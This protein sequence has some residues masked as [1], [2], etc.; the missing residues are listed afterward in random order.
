MSIL[1]TPS[2]R[3]FQ[4]IMLIFWPKPVSTCR[5][6]RVGC[7][8]ARKRS[9]PKPEEACSRGHGPEPRWIILP[10]G[11]SF[12]IEESSSMSQQLCPIGCPLIS[13]SY[14]DRGWRISLSTFANEDS[15][16]LME[17]MKVLSLP[18]WPRSQYWGVLP[19][20][21]WDQSS[22]LERLSQKIYW[23][24]E[25]SSTWGTTSEPVQRG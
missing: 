7:L 23:E 16:N 10:S 9:R 5:L 17:W 8:L 11:K 15:I 2:I 4:R 3:Y 25:G 6:K 20:E 14:G 13:D 19:I 24:L 21:G 22:H 1:S 18:A 12:P